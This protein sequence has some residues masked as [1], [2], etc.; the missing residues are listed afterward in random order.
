[1]KNKGK[2]G[3]VG[4]GK[5]ATVTRTKHGRGEEEKKIVVDI[6]MKRKGK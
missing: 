3:R 1:M 6:I 2:K 5:K 4:R